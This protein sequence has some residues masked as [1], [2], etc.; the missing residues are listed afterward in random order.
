MHGMSLAMSQP[1]QSLLCPH[2]HH[3]TLAH[4]GFP[5]PQLSLNGLQSACMAQVWH[6]CYWRSLLATTEWRGWYSLVGTSTAQAVCSRIRR[7]FRN[8]TG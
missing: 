1:F 5:A 2:N 8:R 7:A 4:S 6:F 3:A